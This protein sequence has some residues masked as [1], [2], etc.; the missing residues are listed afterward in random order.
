M[1][2]VVQVPMQFPPENRPTYVLPIAKMTRDNTEEARP[3]MLVAVRGIMALYPTK[4]ILVHTVSYDLANYLTSNLT[5]RRIVT[6]TSA[7]DRESAI[8]QYRSQPN[9][10]L[11]ASS[12]D[13][14]VD[15]RHDD[16]RVV[17]V[18]K[19]PYPN[20][21]DKQINARLYSK[22]GEHWYNKQTVR[23]LIQMTGRGVRS[24]DDHCD[25]YILD[26][27]FLDLYRSNESL[28]YKWWRDALDMTASKRKLIN[29]LGKATSK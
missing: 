1:V 9:A 16:C 5:S 28:F 18:C 13:R 14:G 29:Q 10:V 26:S 2:A 8:T 22:G 27:K 19:V 4:R 23:T 15:F 24:I 20:R 12:L 3:K 6:Y 21:G 25:N 7:R 17:V 11:I